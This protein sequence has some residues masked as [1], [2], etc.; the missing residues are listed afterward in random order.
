MRFNYK[1]YITRNGVPI[2]EAKA[3]SCIVKFDSEAEV[4]RGLQMVINADYFN[5]DHIKRLRD[6]L[7]Y[8]N[9]TRKFNNTWTF[10]GTKYIDE[11]ISF[12]MFS[13]CLRPMVIIQGKEY[14]LGDFIIFSAPKRMSAKS[15][16][17]QIQ[18]YDRTMILKQTAF[19]DRV[20][21]SAGTSYINLIKQL[22]NACGF[23]NIIS[24]DSSATLQTDREY[25]QGTTYIKVINELLEEIN[26]NRVHM[27]ADNYVYLTRNYQ[28]ANPDFRYSDKSNFKIKEP[29]TLTTD[30]YDLP[31]VLIGI[32]SNPDIE[33]PI[34][35][36]REND[37]VTSQISTVNRGYKVVKVYRLN[38]IPSEAELIDYIDRKYLEATQATETLELET[39]VEPMH[40]FGSMVQI[41]TDLLKGLF[42]EKEWTIKFG[43][44]GSMSHTLERKVIA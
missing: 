42:I 30:I 37:S 5:M 35:Y 34:T 40:K 12:N 9:G 43:I 20:F 22:L 41:D 6:D 38:N 10:K 44:G 39:A 14:S 29:L 23:V 11:T 16:F 8:F 15:S 19:E 21:F 18:G 27:E 4:T 31:N 24:D 17:Y 33:E 26:F 28:K 32:M 1:F 3:T 13:D 2:G 36:R 25:E 7:I